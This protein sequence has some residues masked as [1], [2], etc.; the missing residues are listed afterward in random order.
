MNILFLSTFI[1]FFNLIIFLKF[2]TISKNFIFFDKPDGKLKKHKQPASLIGGLIILVNLFLIIFFLKILKLNDFFFEDRFIYFIV[3]L[4]TFFYFIGLIDDLKN[5]SPNKKLLWIF[6]VITFALYFFSEIRL[7]HI[8][9]SFLNSYI[10][11]EYSFIFLIFSFALLSNAINM[12]DGINLQVISFTIF[13]FFIFILK[14]FFVVFFSLLLIPLIFLGI[15]NYQNKVFLGDGGSYLLSS[16]I[17][18]TFIYQ[19]NN[20]Q[21]FFYGDE[22]FIILFIPAIDMLRLFVLRII[23][24]KNPFKGDLNHLHH[25]V[26]RYFKNSTITVMVN[27][28]LFIL[29][30][31]LLL[32]N[33]A[34][35]NILIIST[36][37]YFF[38]IM[39][40]RFKN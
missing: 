6:L 25:I 27:I 34:T 18:S 28:F 12:F 1:F 36:F 39:L 26:N 9:I 17:G 31:I 29:P 35:Y 30:S 22:I 3:I 21:N 7:N 16:I 15:L 5:L 4:S 10:H 13:I 2:E 32:N 24:K 37:V 40:A 20:F 23:N 38:T 8:K 33:L 14:G 11:F 19:Y